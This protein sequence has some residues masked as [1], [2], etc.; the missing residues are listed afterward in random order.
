MPLDKFPGSG[1]EHYERV[2][3]NLSSGVRNCTPLDK[4]PGSG[5][6]HYEQAE[7]NLSSGV[8]NCTPL[9]K[10]DAPRSS[11]RP[12]AMQVIGQ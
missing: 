3:P 6:E 11:E 5:L 4:F 2:G 10:Q 9:D 7:L 1:V 8:P 12:Q